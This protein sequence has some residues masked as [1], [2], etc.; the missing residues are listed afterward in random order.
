MNQLYLVAETA[1]TCFAI[2]ADAVQSVVT[3]SDI[4]PAPGAAPTV[5]GIAALRSKVITVI[6]TRAAIEGGA[7]RVAD[8]QSLIVAGVDDFLYGLAVDDIHDV[9]DHDG[10]P[11]KLGAA[12]AAGWRRVS[13]GI[14]ELDGSAIVVVDPAVLV[15]SQ[16]S[17]AA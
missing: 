16:D 13:T 15:A 4:I 17:V 8:G 2:P 11:R 14:I 12:F 3:A 10:A 6:D 1:G 7:A 5:A 9:R